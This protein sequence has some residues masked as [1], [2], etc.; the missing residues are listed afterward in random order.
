MKQ[1]KEGFDADLGEEQASEKNA[2]QEFEAVRGSKVAG[3]DQAKA[4]IGL[5][6]QDLAEL[7]QLN[8]EALKVLGNTQGQLGSR[9]LGCLRASGLWSRRDSC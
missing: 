3:I 8:A 4:T 1:T 7:G 5:S 2:V 9:V 6:D